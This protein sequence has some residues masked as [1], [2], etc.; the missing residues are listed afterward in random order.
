MP[1]NRNEHVGK[2]KQSVPREKN[3]RFVKGGPSPNPGGRPRGVREVAEMIFAETSDLR[4]VVKFLVKTYKNG[5]ADLKD[6]LD[7]AKELLNR[8]LGRP[9]QTIELSGGVQ[10]KT[11]LSRATEAEL[12]ALM[13]AAE[14]RERLGGPAQ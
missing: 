6:R 5:K 2:P 4:D 10:V 7:A 11:D 14:I 8:A 13:A 12:D 1:E 3:G 9:P